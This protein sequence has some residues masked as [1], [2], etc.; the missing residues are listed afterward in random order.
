M[1]SHKK[2]TEKTVLKKELPDNRIPRFIEYLH[3]IKT[4]EPH[5]PC[6]FFDS[7]LGIQDSQTQ[8]R[9]QYNQ[10]MKIK[11]IALLLFASVLS[12]SV[13]AETD[14]EASAKTEQEEF[15]SDE[16]TEEGFITSYINRAIE[17]GMQNLPA[18]DDTALV[19][20]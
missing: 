2:C 1:L 3:V 6:S 17:S 5:I 8:E 14:S 9:Q 10:V 12:I 7:E 16:K 20:V 11:H 4:P 19:P 18:P 13:F 15:P